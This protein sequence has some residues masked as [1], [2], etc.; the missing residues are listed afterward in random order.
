M[1][2]LRAVLSLA[3]ALAACGM[4]PAQ[5]AAAVPASWPTYHGDNQRSG[6]DSADAQYGNVQKAWSAALDGAIYGS[7]LVVGTT[8]IAVTENDSVYA[9]STQGSQLW[10]TNL[11]T[12]VPSSSLPCGNINPV[13]ITSTPVADPATNT[14]FTVALLNTPS[15]HYVLAALNIST[16]AVAWQTTLADAANSFDPTIQNQR[17]ALTLANGLVYV[18][19]GGR[20]GDCGNYKGWVMSFPESGSGSL[21]SMPLPEGSD[22]EGGLW[23][24]A[25]GSVDAAGNLYY[26]SGNTSCSS[27]CTYDYGESVIK[28]S[29]SLAILDEFHPSNWQSLNAGDT[30]IGSTG[31][32]Q[33]PGG[34]VFQVGK[35]GDGYLLAGSSLGGANHVTPVFT[36]HVCP[37]QTGD[38]AFGGDAFDGTTIYVPCTNGVVA[39][40]F[41]QAHGRFS[42]LWQ[43]SGIYNPPIV[44]GGYVWV[45]ANAYLYGLQPGSGQTA[46][47]VA[48]GSS[49]S[50]FGTSAA[51]NDQ[52]FVPAG[53]TLVGLNATSHAWH[54]DPGSA[55]D[56]A[57]GG[58]KVFALGTNSVP[59][60]YGVW[61]WT[62]GGWAQFPGGGRA[63]AVDSAGRPWVTNDANEIWSWTGSAWQL[64]PGGAHYVAAGGDGTVYV[65]GTNSVPGG[66]GIWRWGGGVWSALPGGLV[67]L[68]AGNDGSLWGVNSSKAVYR[69]PAG[70]NWAQLPGSASDVTATDVNTAWVVGTNTV[71]GGGGIWSWTGGGWALLPGGAVDLA[72]DSTGGTLWAVNSAHAIFS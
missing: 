19:F 63:L 51:L 42:F 17:G 55:V 37:N 67:D 40:A 35:A 54:L 10:R 14:V 27:N 24:P 12:P 49:S 61:Q 59:G 47:K 13:G 46:F 8:V 48:L 53:A 15:I 7:P 33:L 52:L 60:G 4:A 26:A 16:G 58:G 21:T 30:D 45:D 20:A 1:T 43:A 9:Y 71:L 38:A 70:S 39:L 69:M 41:D 6:H 31:P 18:P 72:I 62:G 36:A 57:A 32:L 66:Y 2:A 68:A 34:Y 23:Q 50:H 56:V 25:G 22:H 28:L 11:G 3:T 65:L 29:P 44:A 5:P 64:E